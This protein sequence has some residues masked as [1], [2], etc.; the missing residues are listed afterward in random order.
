MQTT[1]T[2]TIDLPGNTDAF[3]AGSKLKDLPGIKGISVVTVQ[4][5]KVKYDNHKTTADNITAVVNGT[6]DKH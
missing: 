3:I 5:L 4:Q 1:H 6:I 2:I